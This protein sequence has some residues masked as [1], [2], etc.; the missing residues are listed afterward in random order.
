[1]KN[2]PVAGRLPSY[3]LKHFLSLSLLMLAAALW[4]CSG[5]AFATTTYPP[6]DSFLWGNTAVN[7]IGQTSKVSGKG[8]GYRYLPPKNFD[9]SKKYPVIIFLHGMGESAKD[10][11]SD[12]NAQL[13]A[14]GN[15]ANGALALVSLENQDAYPLFFVAPQNASGLWGAGGPYLLAILNTL[16]TYY[17]N[18]IDEGRIC[19]TGLSAGGFGTWDLP[20]TTVR[21]VFSCLVPMSGGSGT[22]DKLQPDMPIWAFH[23]ANDTTVG[24]TDTES[25]VNSWR[26]YGRKIIFTRYD[27]GNHPIWKTAYQTPQLLPWMMAQRRGQPMTGPVDI[28]IK[29]VSQGGNKLS[30]AVDMPAGLA[31]SR[32]GWSSN[33]T[34]GAQSGTDGSVS[35]TTFT[36]ASA[37][38]LNKPATGGRLA[39]T[40]SQVAGGKTFNWKRYYDIASI[41]SANTLAL[42]TTPSTDAMTQ[43]FTVYREG[44]EE[45][46]FPG[47]G[48][49]SDWTLNNIPL[50]AGF[51]L[52]HAYAELPTWSGLGGKTTVNAPYWVGYAAVSGDTTAPS[53]IIT[54]PSASSV[55]ISG[56]LDIIGTA[57]DTAGVTEL[58]WSSDRGYGGTLNGPNWIISNVPLVNGPNRIMVTA[59]DAKNNIGSATLDVNYTGVSANRTPAVY[60]GAYQVVDWPNNMVT[61]AGTAS[62]DGLP[63]AS[64]LSASWSTVSGPGLVSFGNAYSPSTTASFSQP[65]TYVLRLTASDSLLNASS[66]VVVTVRPSGAVVTAIDAGSAASYTTADGT[67]YAADT[68]CT[69]SK[70]SVSA[71]TVFAGTV[72]QPVYHNWCYSNS[73]NVNYAIP[74]ANG[75]YDV[76]L[77]FSETTGAP[78]IDGMRVFDVTAEGQTMISGLDILAQ[79][80]RLVAYDRVM[81]VT[82][83]D[84]MLNLGFVKVV[85]APT[86]SGI[87]VINVQ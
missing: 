25:S 2:R 37:N 83:S 48:G 55:S 5:S 26:N 6:I 3:R 69:A 10:H 14:G 43:S 13:A 86:I 7:A 28:E 52:V 71:S 40:Y 45:N 42:T 60:A 30:L 33:F 41:P 61:L 19:L 54:N 75:T 39:I 56:P 9:P 21:G 50:S 58:T 20:A 17:P 24:V 77:K 70:A 38:F 65:G 53:V 73:G 18:S 51:N 59:R 84:G 64:A 23:A 4:C 62:D 22:V 63:S 76:V 87:V 82:V 16:K 57:S 47:I 81:R 78:R 49:G 80:G 27:T 85:G 1:M 32:V 15:T 36:S 31:P 72:D 8:W 46:P 66:D 79:A 29:G 34:S 44:K 11:N 67:V 12:N 68:Y 74:I 35:G